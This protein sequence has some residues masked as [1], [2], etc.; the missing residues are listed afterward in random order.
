MVGDNSG[1]H[2]GD[3][4]LEFDSC[5][6]PGC[7]RVLAYS[8][9]EG[10]TLAARVEAASAEGWPV[11]AVFVRQEVLHWWMRY[12]SCGADD[13]LGLVVVE[14]LLRAEV[15]PWLECYTVLG[16]F[17]H[18]DCR[19]GW[20]WIV[21]CQFAVDPCRFCTPC[22]CVQGNCT[23]GSWSWVSCYQSQ[24]FSRHLVENTQVHGLGV[25]GWSFLLVTVVGH[26]CW[27]LD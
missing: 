21:W 23:E 15:V 20:S 11:F 27:V 2:L 14:I 10:D 3:R 26:S 17:L 22:S 6:C 12:S 24:I 9:A 13:W 7:C 16:V 5:N 19:K 25:V 4:V 8:F 1:G 18:I